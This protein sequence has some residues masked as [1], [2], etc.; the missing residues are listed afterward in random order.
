MPRRNWTAATYGTVQHHMCNRYAQY[1][2]SPPPFQVRRMIA[3]EEL[4]SSH[5]QEALEDIK[6]FQRQDF[7]GLFRWGCSGGAVQVGPRGTEGLP[8]CLLGCST[9][10]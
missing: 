1:P 2:I 4:D 3:E 9:D 10:L 5:K 7:E 6:A 8:A